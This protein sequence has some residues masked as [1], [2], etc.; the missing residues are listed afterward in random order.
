M[1]SSTMSQG[2]T[3]GTVLALVCLAHFLNDL[4]QSVIPSAMPLIKENLGLTFAEVGLLTLVIQLTSSILQPL[5]GLAVDKKRHPAALSVG[6]LFT[7]VGVWLLSR[8]AGFYAAL[9]AVALTGCGSAIFHPECVRIAQSASGGKRGSRNPFFRWAATWG[10]PW[11]PWQRP[12]SFCPTAKAISP[13]FPRQPPVRPWCSFLS[14]APGRNS[15]PQQRK[16][17]L[18]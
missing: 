6:M 14:D 16:R 12:S 8:S 4:I 11:G 5:V 2:K 1:P 17:R 7:L 13:G 3:A 10:L 9:A 15:P 18:P